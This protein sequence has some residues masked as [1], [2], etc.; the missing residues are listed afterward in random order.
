RDNWRGEGHMDVAY[1][2][3]DALYPQFIDPN[4]PVMLQLPFRQAILYSIDRQELVDTLLPGQSSVADS[5]LLPGQPQYK[6]IED[7]NV[8]HYPFDQRK[9][10]ELIRGLGYA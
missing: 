6:D 8:V 2:S 5:W 7:K 9:A 3:W 10:D 1:N 4:P